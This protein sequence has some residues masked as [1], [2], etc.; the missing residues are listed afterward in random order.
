LKS[1]TI[2]SV[3]RDESQ[4]DWAN[5]NVNYACELYKQADVGKKFDAVALVGRPEDMIIAQAKEK[6]CD[7]IVMGGYG[8]SGLSEMLMGHVTRKVI[9]M[10]QRPVLVVD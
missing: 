10:S 8:R 2:L 9:A 7:M 5:E 6:N 4:L 3:A 1:I